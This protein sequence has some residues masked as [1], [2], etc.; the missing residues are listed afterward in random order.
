VGFW[1]APSFG[2][3]RITGPDSG[4]WLQTQTT[5]DVRALTDGQGQSTALLDRKGRIFGAFS[6]HHANDEFWIL[7]PS[8]QT[9]Q[10]SE[11]LSSHIFVEEVVVHDASG[12]I[13]TLCVQGP[14]SRRLLAS[15]SNVPIA[16]FAER[17]PQSD[18][19]VTGITLADIECF[20]IQQ[21]WTG[22]DGFLLVV[23]RGQGDPLARAL[24]ARG[25]AAVGPAAQ[26]SLRVEAGIPVYGPD[27]DHGTLVSETP[28]IHTSVSFTKGCYLGQ[29]VV[30]RLR[31]YGT[32]KLMLQGLRLEPGAPMPPRNALMLHE[33]KRIGVVK[34]SAYIGEDGAPVALAYLDRD[35]RTPGQALRFGVREL[36]REL[37]AEVAVLPFH[38]APTRQECA[39]ALYQ[40]ALQ[41]FDRDLHDQDDSAIALLEDAI[42][43]DP[44]FEDAFES[45]GVILN[46][47]HRVDEA[48]R[49]MEVLSRLNPKSVMAHS[50]LSVF[51]MKQGNLDKAE[52]EKAIAK[53]METQLVVDQRQAEAAGEAERRR[54]E[55]EARDRIRMFR[56]VLEIDPEDPLA[57]FGLGSAYLQLQEYAAAVPFLERATEVQKD[58]SAAY[59]SLGKCHE[60][61][62]DSARAQ[63]AY[64]RGISVASRKGDL[65]PMREMERRLNAL[66]T[67]RN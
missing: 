7:D 65:M 58:Y 23:E 46:R 64:T 8:S 32:P 21:S 14:S 41:R 49:A 66:L 44:Y 3:I 17:L 39:R 45:L 10:L 53:L 60:F 22:E 35:H 33:A 38:Q 57:T 5:N 16:N 51:H 42:L 6:L 43:L 37:V 63:D 36:R 19:A 67:N 55:F 31:A 52:D 28:L 9:A 30:A 18:H 50:N 47:H 27:M 4:S 13:E 34:T 11:R 29:E 15:L 61:L 2:F 56:E 1:P 48:I 62:G 54:I 59:L 40:D 26:E 20:V 25:A 24:Q 12:D